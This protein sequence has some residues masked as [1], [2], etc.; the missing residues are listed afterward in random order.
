MAKYLIDSEQLKA[1]LEKTIDLFQ[2]YQYRHGHE[3]PRAREEAIMDVLNSIRG[4]KS[5]KPP[6]GD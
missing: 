5:A 3:E 1:I 2:E 4:V 6:T